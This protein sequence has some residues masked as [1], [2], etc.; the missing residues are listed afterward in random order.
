MYAH[1]YTYM[2]VHVSKLNVLVRPLIALPL[3][4]VVAQSWSV[5]KINENQ[6]IPSSLLSSPGNLKKTVLA[7]NSSIFL[8]LFVAKNVQVLHPIIKDAAS[9]QMW[10]FDTMPGAGALQH[11]I[12][13]RHPISLYVFTSHPLRYVY[14]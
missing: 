11:Y 5:N 6:R 10:H 14:T 8:N 7:I 12:N 13:C 3:V 4:A 2:N 1:M 9:R